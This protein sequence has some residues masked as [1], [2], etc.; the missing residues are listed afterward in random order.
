MEKSPPQQL[1]SSEH[2]SS[3]DLRL[4]P[5]VQTG[6]DLLQPP[7]T[8]QLQH[9]LVHRADQLLQELQCLAQSLR[10]LLAS[11]RSQGHGHVRH[12]SLQVLR[13]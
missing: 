10:L 9:L 6:L 11:C 1:S 12:Q 3:P 8:V 4:G 2:S 13:C 7:S 5:G